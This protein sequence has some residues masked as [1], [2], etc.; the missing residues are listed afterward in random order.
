[1]DKLWQIFH[2]L[3]DQ[4]AEPN[5]KID[6]FP[7]T[8]TNLDLFY[9]SS[10]EKLPQF[11]W[12]KRNVNGEQ[13]QVY[14]STLILTTTSPEGSFFSKSLPTTTW[15]TQVTKKSA[16]NFILAPTDERNIVSVNLYSGTID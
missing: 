5:C 11:D 7:Q 4:G 13:Q 2:S 14:K 3:L 1:M 6:P 10:C 8:F 9:L 16:T 15:K 12:L